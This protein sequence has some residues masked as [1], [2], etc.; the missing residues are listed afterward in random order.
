MSIKQC[1]GPNCKESFTPTTWN[2]KY[3][4]TECKRE[5]EKITKRK[6]FVDGFKDL[7]IENTIENKPR[8]LLLDIET[9]PNL[10]YTWG[11]W[12]QNI[13][14]NQIEETSKVI[15]FSAKWLGSSKKT[16]MFHSMRDGQETM[17]KAAWD[18]LDQAD[19]VM[20][21]NGTSFDIPHLNR[22][23]LEGNF[24]PP[25]PYQNIDLFR[26]AKKFKF[27]SRKLEHVS[28]QLGLEGKVQHEGFNLWRKCLQG[29]EKAWQSMER[30]NRQDV[31]LMEDMYEILLP[32]IPNLPNRRLYDVDAGCPRCGSTH[33]QRRGVTRTATSIFQQFQCQKCRGWFKEAH[34]SLGVDF[35]DM[36]SC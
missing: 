28:R 3:H 10:V 6:A 12:D 29:D 21:Y 7:L 17:V 9:S 34:R 2:Q 4:D 35:R 27:Q 16:T 32:W 36:A 8:I 18:L 14:L 33:V 19:A 30:Y 22:E 11:L 15:C 26:L 31:N 25:S 20:H 23:F 13:G 5:A 24:G 1:E